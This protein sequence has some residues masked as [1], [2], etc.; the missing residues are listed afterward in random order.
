MPS[1]EPLPIEILLPSERAQEAW[2]QC[3]AT[4]GTMKETALRPTAIRRDPQHG[5]KSDSLLASSIARAR[6]EQS[7]P[8]GVRAANPTPDE[9]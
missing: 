5:P 9:D 2:R 6:A 4:T 7:G 3:T 1:D 8:A